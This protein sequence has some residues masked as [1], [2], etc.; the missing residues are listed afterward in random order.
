MFVQMFADGSPGSLDVPITTV[1][2]RAPFVI[3]ALLEAGPDRLQ[4]AVRLP[5]GVK[6]LYGAGKCPVMFAKHQRLKGNT[7][8]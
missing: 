2:Q 7:W 6:A 5:K 3:G 4:S 1:S 8:T